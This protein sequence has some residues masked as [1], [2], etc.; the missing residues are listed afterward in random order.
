MSKSKEELVREALNSACGEVT[1]AA[2]LSLDLIEGERLDN[3]RRELAR[4]MEIIDGQI[5]VHLERKN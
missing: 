3:V 2:K 5:L 4:I 1:E